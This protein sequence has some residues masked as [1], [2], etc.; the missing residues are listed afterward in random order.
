[1]V[2]LVVVG[3]PSVVVRPIY[4]LPNNNDFIRQIIRVLL[5]LR[6]CCGTRWCCWG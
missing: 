1:M 2:G 4:Y 3:R 5:V 6:S